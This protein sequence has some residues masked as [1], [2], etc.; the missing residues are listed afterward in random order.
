MKQGSVVIFNSPEKIRHA[1]LQKRKIKAYSIDAAGIAMTRSDKKSTNI[2]MLGAL[3]KMVPAISAK[4]AKAAMESELADAGKG[5]AA[6]FE[7]G[8]K[9]L[10]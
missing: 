10:R 7:E 3:I 6:A 4:S 9:C 5:M 2:I 1:A 8:Y